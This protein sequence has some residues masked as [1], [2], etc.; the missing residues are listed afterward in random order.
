MKTEVHMKYY[1]LK[2]KE[3]FKEHCFSTLLM[4]GMMFYWNTK[5]EFDLWNEGNDKANIYPVGQ[6]TINK[7]IL[8]LNNDTKYYYEWAIIKELTLESDPEY[9]V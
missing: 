4:G 2:P 9:F 5:K 3:W 1:Q 8:P 7:G 6:N